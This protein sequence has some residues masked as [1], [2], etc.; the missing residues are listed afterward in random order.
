M[1]ILRFVLITLTA[2][3]VKADTV[4]TRDS[5]SWNGTVTRIGNGV[6]QLNAGFPTGKPTL[7]F[8][9]NYVRSIEFNTTIYNQGAVPTNLPKA[10]GKP[11]SGTVYIKTQ[12]PQHCTNITMGSGSLLCDGKGL[13]LKNVVRILI[14]TQ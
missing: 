12:P 14:D 5:S 9:A 10:N 7:S 1:G 2:F 8:G 3:A 11:F 6:L 4:T 13:D